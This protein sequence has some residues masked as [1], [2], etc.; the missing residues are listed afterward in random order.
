[1]WGIHHTRFPKSVLLRVWKVRSG[2]WVRWVGWIGWQRQTGNTPG[3]PFSLS[4]PFPFNRMRE[5][6][7]VIAVRHPPTSSQHPL[8]ITRTYTKPSETSPSSAAPCSSRNQVTQRENIGRL[9][10]FR[11]NG[12]LCKCGKRPTIIIS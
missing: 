2:G 5:C 3:M 8:Q 6:T 4:F 1:M 11:E 7:D 12:G 9:A 10:C